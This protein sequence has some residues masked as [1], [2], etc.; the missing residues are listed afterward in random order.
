MAHLPCLF[1]TVPL[2]KKLRRY[3]RFKIPAQTSVIMK[4]FVPLTLLA[5]PKAAFAF[6]SVTSLVSNSFTSLSAGAGNPFGGKNAL[7]ALVIG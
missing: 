6:T 4:L 5:A 1:C 7:S 3:F 2:S